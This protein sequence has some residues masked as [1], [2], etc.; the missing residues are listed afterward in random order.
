MSAFMQ[1]ATIM[2]AWQRRRLIAVALSRSLVELR[3]S[4]STRRKKA[5]RLFVADNAIQLVHTLLCIDPTAREKLP[6]VKTA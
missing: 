5:A 2:R 3:H 4:T 6:H 1:S